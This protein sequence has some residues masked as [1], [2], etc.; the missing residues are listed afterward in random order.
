MFLL[1]FFF[2]QLLY[3]VECSKTYLLFHL[4]LNLKRKY[5]LLLQQNFN[6]KLLRSITKSKQNLLVSEYLENSDEKKIDK[7]VLSKSW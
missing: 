4:S 5:C 6:M 1:L 3:L 7:T 2:T